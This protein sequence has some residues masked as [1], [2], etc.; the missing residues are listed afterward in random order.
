MTVS[1]G[2]NPLKSPENRWNSQH[3]DLL[4]ETEEKALKLC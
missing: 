2:F 1:E 4:M 3:P